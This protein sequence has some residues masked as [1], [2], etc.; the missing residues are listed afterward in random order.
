MTAPTKPFGLDAAVAEAEKR[1]KN[2]IARTAAQQL[3][4]WREL[5]RKPNVH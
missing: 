2:H 1:I 5:W 4:R 3:R